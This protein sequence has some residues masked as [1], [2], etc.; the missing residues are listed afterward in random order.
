MSRLR[1]RRHAGNSARASDTT[2]RALKAG[3]WPVRQRYVAC[4]FDRPRK[5]PISMATQ[6][7]ILGDDRRFIWLCRCAMKVAFCVRGCLTKTPEPA[8]KGWHGL[9]ATPVCGH[10]PARPASR[11]APAQWRGRGRLQ[12]RSVEHASRRR[13][14]TN[15]SAILSEFARCYCLHTAR[16]QAA[17]QGVDRQLSKPLACT[18]RWRKSANRMVNGPSPERR[19]TARL[20]RERTNAN[21][22]FRPELIALDGER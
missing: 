14:P 7:L 4:C 17:C 16:A 13:G 5:M 2:A 19:A 10:P 12:K 22:R 6:R 20:R 1:A 18:A 15:R 8:Q 3:I 11:L 21:V 9:R